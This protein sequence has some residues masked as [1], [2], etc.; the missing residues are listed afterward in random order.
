MTKQTLIIFFNEH[1]NFNGIILPIREKWSITAWFYYD[2]VSPST[3][4]EILRVSND[5]S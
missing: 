3:N 2:T 1:I 4:S 5:L